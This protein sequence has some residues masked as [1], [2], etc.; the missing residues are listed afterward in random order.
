YSTA[1]SKIE[2]G[3][4]GD[5]QDVLLMLRTGQIDFAELKD[6]FEQIMPRIER[7]SLKRNPDRFRR[8]FAALTSMWLTEALPKR[9]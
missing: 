5:F 1:L 2:R 4:E 7:E 8:N 9:L 6:A 3:R